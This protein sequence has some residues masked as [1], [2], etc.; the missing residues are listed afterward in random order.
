MA[1]NMPRIIGASLPCGWGWIRLPRLRSGR[2]GCASC[3][4]RAVDVGED[5][6][7]HVG[8]VHGGDDGAVSHRHDERGVVHEDDRVARALRLSP[9]DAGPEALRRR[10]ID[11]DAT[12]LQAG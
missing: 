1:E 5:V 7:A 8:A 12:T 11:L 4:D 10:G 3:D 6:V 2:A 9:A